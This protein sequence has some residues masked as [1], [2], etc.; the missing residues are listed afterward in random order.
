MSVSDD[1]L[2]ESTQHLYLLEQVHALPHTSG[3]ILRMHKQKT[4]NDNDY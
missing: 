1:K 4:G 2:L 3:K